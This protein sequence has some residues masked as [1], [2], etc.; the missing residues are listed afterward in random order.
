[1]LH[2]IMA[3]D[4][5]L[6]WLLAAF[7]GGYLIGS[8]PFGILLAR[9]FDL[10]DLRKVGSGNIGATNVLRTG[11]KAAAALTL[12]MDM[13]KGLAA[14]LLFL[15]WGDL[16]GQ[17]AGIGAVLGHCLPVWLRFRGGKGVATF[18]G[19]V[20]ALN[21]IAGALVCATWLAVAAL[22]RISSAAA[23]VAAALAPVWIW[24]VDGPRA[25]LCLVLLAIWI[26]VR[27]DANIRR[28]VAGTETKIGQKG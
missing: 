2:D 24:L 13:G 27:H 26:W 14:V 3:W 25:V 6:P 16:A 20:L 21:L 23:L 28:L 1:M 18:I 15:G 4:R 8:V 10:G 5:A 7:A 17:A 11:N 12:V 9:L 19:V 22:T